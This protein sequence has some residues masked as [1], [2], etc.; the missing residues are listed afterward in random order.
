[1]KAGKITE[2][3]YIKANRRASRQAEIES[4]SASA[5]LN[6][7]HRSKK[8]YD[9][10][11]QKADDKRHLPSFFYIYSEKLTLIISNDHKTPISENAAS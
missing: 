3:D 9:R 2:R 8:E 5:N 4:R 11:R 1:M 7:I 10:K 6:R